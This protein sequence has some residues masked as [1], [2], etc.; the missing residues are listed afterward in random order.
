MAETFNLCS[1]VVAEVVQQR[2]GAQAR[3]VLVDYNGGTGITGPAKL[4]PV[5]RLRRMQQIRPQPSH[6]SKSY[7]RDRATLDVDPETDLGTP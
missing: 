1:R 6:D 3:P 2:I 5:E 7:G 4:E